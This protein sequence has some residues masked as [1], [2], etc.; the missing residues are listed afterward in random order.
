MSEPREN[1]R[2]RVITIVI[3]PGYLCPGSNSNKYLYLVSKEITQKAAVLKAYC[4]RKQSEQTRKYLPRSLKVLING[5][6][7]PNQS[8]L[9]LK[10]VH[11]SKLYCTSFSRGAKSPRQGRGP[12]QIPVH[13]TFVTTPKFYVHRRPTEHFKRRAAFDGTRK[14]RRKKVRRVLRASFPGSNGRSGARPSE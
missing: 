9:T 4:L 11:S 6:C 13:G 10:I 14:E 1:E 8:S 5:R 3:R 12:H 2:S 7:F